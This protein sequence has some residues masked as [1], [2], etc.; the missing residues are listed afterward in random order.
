MQRLYG[1]ENLKPGGDRTSE[2]ARLG[3]HNDCFLAKGGDQG[4]FETENNKEAGQRKWLEQEGLSVMV[5]GESCQKNDKT[6][7]TEAKKQIEKQRFTYLN[8]DF[9]ETVRHY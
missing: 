1:N 4:T 2:R 6:G 5:G 9:K 7:C 8:T 3:I